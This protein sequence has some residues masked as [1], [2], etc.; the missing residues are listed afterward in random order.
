[1]TNRDTETAIRVTA[2]PSTVRPPNGWAVAGL[3]WGMAVWT[4][5]LLV[6]L[7]ISFR[8][9]LGWLGF[10]A[11]HAWQLLAA[12]AGLAMSAAGW[13]RSGLADQH[14]R[15]IYRGRIT[16]IIGLVINSLMC[17]LVVLSLLSLASW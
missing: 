12:G 11:A 5:G 13:R 10:I 4:L 17:M 15:S 2:S 9:G 7:Y 8:L 3:I 6:F 16:S 14:G 1:M